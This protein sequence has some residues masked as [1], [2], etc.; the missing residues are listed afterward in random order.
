MAN[1][2]IVGSFSVNGV[3][4]I[5]T[6]LLKHRLVPDFYEMWPEKFNNKTNGITPR[7]WLL[8]A[9][10]AL[11]SFITKHIGDGWITDLQQLRKLTP[12]AD[13]EKALTELDNIQQDAKIRLAEYVEKT[14]GIKLNTQ[15]LFDC[16]V[17]RIHEYKR[18]LLNAMHIMN[19]YFDIIESGKMPATPKVYIFSGKA[20]PS[21]KMAKLII[22]LINNMAQI[23]NQDKR[24]Q[25]MIKVIFIPNYNVSVAE[26]VMPAADVSE[27]ISTAGFE[28]SGTGNMKMTLNGALTIGTLDGANVEIMRE[29][30]EE[31]FYLFGLTAEQVADAHLNKTHRPWDY[32]HNDN[33]I[34]RVMDSLQNGFWAVEKDSK[35]IFSPI[36][37]DIMFKDYYM[38][39]ADFDS[40]CKTHERIENDFLNRKTWVRK[41]LLNTAGSGIFSIDRTVSEYARDIW[42][43]KASK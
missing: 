21:Y 33:R 20:A 35:D 7:R 13:N 38:L 32:Y 11:A 2:A 27:Q 43:V 37:Q 39:L 17:K 30:G 18:Q 23:I 40:Y 16:Q 24:V 31:N 8:Q 6:E 22:K 4:Q 41:S 19:E 9:D 34:Q 26:I 36:F 3:A 29:V 10:S 1:L 28:A 5:H 42:H 15:A 14:M 12:L 25:D